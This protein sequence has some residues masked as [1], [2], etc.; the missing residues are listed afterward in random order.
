MTQPTENKQSLHE[1]MIISNENDDKQNIFVE[2]IEVI[3]KDSL[4]KLEDQKELKTLTINDECFCCICLESIESTTDFFQNMCSKEHTFHYNC[5]NSWGKECKI[6]GNAMT[7][8]LCREV[9]PRLYDRKLQQCANDHH[10]VTMIS[11]D[12]PP[13]SNVTVRNETLYSLRVHSQRV[14]NRRYNRTRYAFA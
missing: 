2:A 13:R 1:L 3:L 7:C 6:K 4:E 14:N 5:M 8:P 10:Y 12:S 11:K 9:L